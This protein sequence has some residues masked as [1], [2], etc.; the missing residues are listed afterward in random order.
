MLTPQGTGPF[1]GYLSCRS[2]CL[3]CRGSVSLWEGPGDL[4]FTSPFTVA[5][6]QRWLGRM[7]RALG[8]SSDLGSKWPSHLSGPCRRL[9]AMMGLEVAWWPI[10]KGCP[11]HREGVPQVDISSWN[12][13]APPLAVL[14]PSFT[15]LVKLLH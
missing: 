13:L 7:N 4:A 6:I 11:G 10:G 14:M 5:G 12:F 3:C 9:E 2:Q 8:T 15:S 1:E